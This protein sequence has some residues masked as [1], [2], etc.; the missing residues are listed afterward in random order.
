MSCQSAVRLISL[1]EC[2]SWRNFDMES[3]VK[4]ISFGRDNLYLRSESLPYLGHD[5]SLRAARI[6]NL[7]DS[8]R[9][10]RINIKRSKCDFSSNTHDLFGKHRYLSILKY[11]TH[12]YTPLSSIYTYIYIYIHWI[13]L[14]Y[15]NYSSLIRFYIKNKINISMHTKSFVQEDCFVISNLIF[16]SLYFYSI[17]IN[18]FDIFH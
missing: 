1:F 11:C 4:W 16:P 10:H 13:Y 14:I 12:I 6:P 5:W 15:I 9:N 3:L 7:G 18:S 2:R 17:V 8:K